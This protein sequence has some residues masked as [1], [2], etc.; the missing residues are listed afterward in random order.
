MSSAPHAAPDGGLTEAEATW[1]WQPTPRGPRTSPP[2]PGADIASGLDT[3][4]PTLVQ[5]AEHDVLLDEDLELARADAGRRRTVEVTTY[6]GMIHGFWRHPQL[7]DAAEESLAE[8][9]G[10]LDRHV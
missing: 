7:F 5:I 8:I 1:Y 2:R 10:F 4:P 9:A 3:L 6:P